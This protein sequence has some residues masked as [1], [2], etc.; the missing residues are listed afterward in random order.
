[1]RRILVAWSAFPQAVLRHAA[2]DLTY[3]RETD[4]QTEESSTLLSNAKV[5]EFDE[6]K[7]AQLPKSSDKKPKKVL[8]VL[9]DKE[10]ASLTNMIYD[11]HYKSEACDGSEGVNAMMFQARLELTYLEEWAQRIADDSERRRAIKKAVLERCDYF[12]PLSLILGFQPFFGC[13]IECVQP[14]LCPRAETESWTHWLT[15]KHLAKAK[16]PLRLLDVCSGTGCIGIALAK[17]LPTAHVLALDILPEAVEV[18]NRNAK[19]NHISAERYECVESNMFAAFD[20]GGTKAAV[21]LFDVIVSNPP[22]ILPEQYDSL[23]PTV[24]NWESKYALVGDPS[25]ESRQYLY[26]KELCE[27]GASLLKPATAREESLHSAPSIVIEV[28]LQ[29][30]RIASIMERHPAWDEV[31]LHV[32]FANQPRWISARRK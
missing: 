22:Y 31:E 4:E 24:K 11:A 23:P 18:S 2:S 19:R 5:M 1:M 13:D 27:R 28:G 3:V 16:G 17:H 30:D 14:L 21:P 29:A 6:A 25:R 12:K 9:N 32:D 8:S 10:K 7:M 20:N 15:S 26:F